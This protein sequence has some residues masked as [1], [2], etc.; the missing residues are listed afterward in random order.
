MLKVKGVN[1]ASLIK[2]MNRLLLILQMHEI[3]S[4]NNCSSYD[5]LDAFKL[6]LFRF[7]LNEL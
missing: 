6:I 7:N 4:H 3:N 2:K 1:Q 5:Y